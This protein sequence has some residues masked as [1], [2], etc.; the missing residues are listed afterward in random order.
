[1]GFIQ[2]SV[3]VDLMLFRRRWCLFMCNFPAR[4]SEFST[5]CWLRVPPPNCRPG[6]RDLSSLL[7]VDHLKE[8][9]ST[10]SQLISF[11]YSRESAPSTSET[12]PKPHVVLMI[13]LV[14]YSWELRTFLP[15]LGLGKNWSSIASLR[16]VA[17]LVWG[18]SLRAIEI[19]V[20]AVL[21][22]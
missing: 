17:R 8:A 9:T 6:K 14:E 20:G 15:L 22:D 18:L 11:C 7:W 10:F 5:F 2:S 3:R 19:F 16:I 4:H 12:I 1:M 13:S 21:S